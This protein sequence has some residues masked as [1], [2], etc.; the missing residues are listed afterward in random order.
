[1]VSRFQGSG[2]EKEGGFLATHKQD[3]NA[4]VTGGDWRHG[5]TDI[6]MEPIITSLGGATV[7][8]TLENLSAFIVSE[9]SGFISIGKADGYDG[10]AA[11][12]Y[13]VGTPATPLLADAFAAAFADKRLQN[14]GAV[15]VL[16]GT[17]ALL[18]TVSVPPGITIMGELAGTIIIGHIIEGSM[19]KILRGTENTRI[20][21]D[22]GSG[23]LRLE[24]GEPLDTTTFFNLILADNLDGYVQ[25]GGQPIAT[26]Q[27]VP[28]VDCEIGSQFSALQCRKL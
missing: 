4:H 24:A 3:F 6:D 25:A 18:S 23:D 21:G 15:L 22:S 20:G 9:G 26:M 11:G 28:M 7:Q 19:F 2:R 8:Q 14:G 1:M 17:Y 12:V 27:T 16:A 13:N 5:A 10:Y